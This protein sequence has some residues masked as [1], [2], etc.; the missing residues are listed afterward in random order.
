MSFFNI[1]HTQLIAVVIGMVINTIAKDV[2]KWCWDTLKKFAMSDTIKAKLKTIFNKANLRIFSDLIMVGF[3]LYQI[4][5]IGWTDSPLSGK[6][7]LV[8]AVAAF[9]MVIMIISLLMGLYQ[10]K[11]T[12]FKNK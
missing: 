11:M 1:D 10:A 4:I 3:F 6:D 5:S 12:E 7:V 2:I 8:M 9:L